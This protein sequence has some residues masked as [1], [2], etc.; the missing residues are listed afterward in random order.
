MQVQRSIRAV[1]RVIAEVGIVLD[2]AHQREQRLVRPGLARRMRDQA[3][4]SRAIGRTTA[5]LLTDEPPPMI[6]P[7]SSGNDEPSARST[8]YIRTYG[9]SRIELGLALRVGDDV[10]ERL[11]IGTGLDEQHATRRILAGARPR[12]RSR[13]SRRRRR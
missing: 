4:K 8:S 3:A 9:D 6:R 7:D 2:G 5:R 13:R 11:W 12:S 10:G 1:D